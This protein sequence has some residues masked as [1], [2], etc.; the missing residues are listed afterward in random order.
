MLPEGTVDSAAALPKR[1]ITK[2][3]EMTFAFMLCG[4]PTSANHTKGSRVVA[5][6]GLKGPLNNSPACATGC[7]V[8]H[9]RIVFHLKSERDTIRPE[10]QPK[11]D[12]GN[13]PQGGETDGLRSS[14]AAFLCG[15]MTLP[16]LHNP[17]FLNI[18]SMPYS[19]DEFQFLKSPNSRWSHA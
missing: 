7:M 3:V 1:G 9:G 4:A 8:K 10:L 11:S 2:P 15:A 18:F 5:P 17:K 16:R 14:S 13:N 12:Q 6:D 19:S